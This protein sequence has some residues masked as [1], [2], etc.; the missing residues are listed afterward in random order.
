VHRGGHCW[1]FLPQLQAWKC[2][3]ENSLWNISPLVYDVFCRCWYVNRAVHA[4]LVLFGHLFNFTAT[5]AV[6]FVT[7]LAFNIKF[8]RR[9]RWGFNFNYKAGIKNGNLCRKIYILC[10]LEG[11]G[12]YYRTH[13][14]HLF[15]YNQ[16]YAHI[17]ASNFIVLRAP[18]SFL[19]ARVWVWDLI[20]G[21]RR[22]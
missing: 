9:R 12:R 5:S 3:A 14:L 21:V 17:N 19:A 20:N 1:W 6:F 8:N 22:P 18:R 4:I 7:R 16:R 11:R 13:A 15:K 2:K 10:K